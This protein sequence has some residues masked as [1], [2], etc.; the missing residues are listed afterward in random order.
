[1]RVGIVT[2]HCSYNFG[3]A[4]QAWALKRAIEKMGHDVQV[5]D[6]RSNNFNQ[7]RLLR[8]D[9]LKGVVS[10]LLFFPGNLRRKKS[11]ESFVSRELDTTSRYADGDEFLMESELPNQFD[12]FVCG[13][14]QI[15]NLDCTKGPVG[16]FFLSFAG[17]SR[18]V[19]YSPSLAHTSFMPRYFGPEQ[20]KMIAGWL[21]RFSA[22]SVREASTVKTFQP[23]CPI[24]IKTCIDPTLLLDREDYSSI[25]APS[26]ES[27]GTLL[28]YMLE[29]NP[30]LVKYADLVA[31]HLDL[32]I[33]YISK[34]PIMFNSPSRNYYGIGPSEFLGLVQGSAAV[35]TNSFHATV[36]SILFDKPFQTFATQLSG[37]R[38]RELL[39]SLKADG[40]LTDGASF[41]V[42]ESI[43]QD[44][45]GGRFNEIREDSLSFLEK[46]LS[47]N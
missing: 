43:S 2:F 41:K 7:Y 28:V 9:T 46:A 24:Q 45:L 30:A 22:V 19:A 6:Y 36:F 15:W 44:K 3:S 16:P 13:S 17:D 34:R 39:Q 12:C 20:Q 38:M 47:A 18:R 31:S 14:D 33:S 8:A 23:F 25:V 37:S 4:L 11:F 26:S 40:N 32:K 35:V 10:N 27:E 42:P 21:S 5:V 29:N 1:M